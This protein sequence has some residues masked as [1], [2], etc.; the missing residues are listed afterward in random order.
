[1]VKPLLLEDISQ[2]QHNAATKREDHAEGQFRS[3][4]AKQQKNADC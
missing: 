2:L 4:A 1:M 3:A